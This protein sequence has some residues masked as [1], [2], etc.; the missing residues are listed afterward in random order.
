LSET[1]ELAE[2]SPFGVNKLSP[3]TTTE[4]LDFVRMTTLKNYKHTKT[5]T[6]R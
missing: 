2:G 5:N 4:I 1:N 3:K 6:E